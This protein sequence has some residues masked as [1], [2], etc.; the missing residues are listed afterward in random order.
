MVI[1]IIS[2]LSP[3][4]QGLEGIFSNHGYIISY[5][6]VLTLAG[7]PSRES[8]PLSP[9]NKCEGSTD[10]E[11]HVQIPRTAKESWWKRPPWTDTGGQWWVVMLVD[12]GYC[13]M[14]GTG[15]HVN[16]V[17]FFGHKAIV[18]DNSNGRSS[19]WL[20]PAIQMMVKRQLRKKLRW[21]IGID[22]PDLQKLWQFCL[23]AFFSADRTAFL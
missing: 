11:G 9:R 15:M 19:C 8:Q 23:R 5:I 17:K 21:F 10:N 20:L 12:D 16:N 4:R 13:R 1:G 3:H 7:H 22:L 18:H 2:S 6:P 14:V